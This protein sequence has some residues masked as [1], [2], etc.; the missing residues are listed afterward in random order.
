MLFS[1]IINKKIITE[2]GNFVGFVKDIIINFKDKKIEY[3]SLVDIKEIIKEKDVKNLRKKV[4][5]FDKIKKI[6]EVV[7]IRD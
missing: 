7:I 1:N 4:I 3:I 6:G 2:S 5:K